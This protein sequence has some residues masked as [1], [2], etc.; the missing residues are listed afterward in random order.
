MKCL[1]LRDVLLGAWTRWHET[2]HKEEAISTLDN[3]FYEDSATTQQM[4]AVLVLAEKDQRAELE[5]ACR[6][7]LLDGF[8]SI[9]A[10]KKIVPSNFN[11]SAVFLAMIL[12][13]FSR[14]PM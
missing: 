8:A 7:L 12:S 4:L 14:N 5:S 13:G 10:I 1:F 2:S 6:S 11:G 9:I 3:K